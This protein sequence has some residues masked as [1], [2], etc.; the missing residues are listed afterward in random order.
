MALRWVLLAAL[1]LVSAGAAA[2]APPSSDMGIPMLMR[3]GAGG[4]GILPT[5]PSLKP[6]RR[7][8][9]GGSVHCR[10]GISVRL[11]MPNGPDYVVE[12][13]FG[14]PDVYQGAV[15]IFPGE[16]LS[17]EADAGSDGPTNLSY[18]EA[19][20]HPDRT[21]TLTFEQAA[22]VEGG[23]GMRLTATNPFA[24]AVRFNVLTLEPSG[25]SQY[26]PINCG[27][28]AHG[29]LQ[30]KWLFPVWQA[31]IAKLTFVSDESVAACAP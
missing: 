13:S 14:G 4:S 11:K 10:H 7:P 28:P 23:Y 9:C 27:V 30:Q 5:D 8:I 12:N 15:F 6:F 16:T 25:R 21:L 31:V 26:G 3:G 17:V 19:A 18:V 29:S 1:M 24:R 22:D 2:E 20:E